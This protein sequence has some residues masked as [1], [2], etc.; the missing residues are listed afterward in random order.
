MAWLVLGLILFLGPHSLRGWGEGVRT[1][2]LGRL[3]EGPYKG[4]YSLATLGGFVLLIHGYGQARL[5]PTVL[6]A[7]P[8][9][10][11]HLSWL[12]MVASLVLLSVTYLP[13]SHLKQAVGHPMMLGVGLWSVAHLL[14]NGTLADLL[15]FGGFLAWIGVSYPA[16]RRRDRASAATPPAPS[17]AVDALGIAVGVGLWC[18]LAFHLHAWLFGVDP[19]A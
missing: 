1:A 10:G 5:D 18:A 13:R 19:L 7:P 15:L 6:Y 14:A 17:W 12:L 8:V 4:L 16:A 3:G 11:R 9:G 2:L